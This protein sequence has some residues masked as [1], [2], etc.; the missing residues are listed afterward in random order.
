MYLRFMSC[1]FTVVLGSWCALRTELSD[2]LWCGRIQRTVAGTV[3]GMMTT[4]SDQLRLLVVVPSGVRL[5]GWTGN[6]VADL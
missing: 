2:V 3:C 1:T 4:E 5:C 6:Y